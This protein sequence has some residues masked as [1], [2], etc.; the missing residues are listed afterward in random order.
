M[1]FFY[2]L[3]RFIVF[4][5]LDLVQFLGIMRNFTYEMTSYIYIQDNRNDHQS[6]QPYLL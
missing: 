6:L 3:M 4:S 5:N 2:N 1:F